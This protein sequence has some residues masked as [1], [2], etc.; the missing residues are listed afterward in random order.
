MCVLVVGL[1]G[2]GFILK[3]VVLDVKGMECIVY[4]KGLVEMEVLVDI[5]IWLL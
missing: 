4:V 3:S 2:L 5:V 1:F